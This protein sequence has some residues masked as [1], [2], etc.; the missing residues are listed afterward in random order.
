[1]TGDPHN[2]E[3]RC[4][5]CR[6]I[7]SH[8]RGERFVHFCVRFPPAVVSDNDGDIYSAWPTT[9]PRDWCGEFVHRD[10]PLLQRRIEREASE[11]AWRFARR[12][13]EMADEDKRQRGWQ[14]MPQRPLPYDLGGHA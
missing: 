7:D 11:A 9:A 3:A 2:P 8:E 12:I 4:G 10:A 6:F 13:D 14:D 5:T 1:M